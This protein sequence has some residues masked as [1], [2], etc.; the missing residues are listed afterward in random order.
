MSLRERLVRLLE[1]GNQDPGFELLDDT[2]LI[3]SGAI[4]SLG[5][6]QL[7]QW[8]EKEINTTLDLTTLSPSEDWETIADILRFIE[9]HRR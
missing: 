3:R 2:S 1:E 9:T 7:A 4:D 6:F 5:L 8:I